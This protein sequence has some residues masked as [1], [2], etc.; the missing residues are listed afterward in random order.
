MATS[1]LFALSRASPD[2]LP[3]LA[4]L[5]YRCF[6]PVVREIF[7]GCKTEDDLPRLVRRHE[8]LMQQDS[9]DVW[10]KVT[11]QTTGRV[12]A[13]SNWKVY[14]NGPVPASADEEPPEW[15]EGEALEKSRKIHRAL[16]EARRKANP[17]GFVHLHICYTDPDYRRQGAGGLMMQWGCDLADQLFLPAWIEASP[18]GNHLYRRHGFYDFSKVVGELE[19]THMRRD[20]RRTVIEGGK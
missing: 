7:M 17:G 1:K 6:P 5:Q 4:R 13:A 20:A 11:D 10:I 14:V 12:V 15:L 9:S 2:D 19:G 3:E 18:E 8:K 16:N